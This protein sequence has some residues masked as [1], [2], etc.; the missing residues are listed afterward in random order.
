MSM[1][2]RIS[3]LFSQV[4]F[5]LSFDLP[6]RLLNR[7]VFFE[8]NVAQF[9]VYFVLIVLDLYSEHNENDC[10]FEWVLPSG[11]SALFCGLLGRQSTPYMMN[12][13]Q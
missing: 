11:S 12:M 8:S 1:Y 7:Y 13:V 3:N 6:I 9:L 5:R 4:S 10:G 2:I